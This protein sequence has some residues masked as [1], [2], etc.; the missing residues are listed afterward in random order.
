MASPS[1]LH[2]FSVLTCVSN[3][4]F[5]LHPRD[6]ELRESMRCSYFSLSF[7]CVSSSTSCLQAWRRVPGLTSQTHVSV[8]QNWS[9]RILATNAELSTGVRSGPGPCRWGSLVSALSPC[10]ASQGN[11]PS[12]EENEKAG[13][14]DPRKC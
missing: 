7:P 5:L 6:E 11:S 2:N 10:C 1:N 13:P 3:T 12:H 8:Q 4:L 9:D 14:C